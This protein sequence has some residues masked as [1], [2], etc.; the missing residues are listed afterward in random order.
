MSKNPNIILRVIS[1]VKDDHYYAICL[2]TDIV[3]Q[4]KSLIEVKNKIIDAVT[5]YMRSFNEKEI[6]QEKFIRKAPLKYF[7][8]L[9]LFALQFTFYQIKGSINSAEYDPQSHHLKLA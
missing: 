7:F 4:G 2:D 3:V 1:Y 8:R 9:W 6:E 5:V